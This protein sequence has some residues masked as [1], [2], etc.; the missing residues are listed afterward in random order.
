MCKGENELSLM[1]GSGYVSH[2]TCK[3]QGQRLQMGHNE[4]IRLE[5]EISFLGLSVFKREEIP[6]HCPNNDDPQD[7]TTRFLKQSL[8]NVQSRRN[9]IKFKKSPVVI[10]T[11]QRQEDLSPES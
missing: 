10:N 6:L 9:K 8:S 4:C 7:H 1:H 5:K 2:C 11:E 3:D